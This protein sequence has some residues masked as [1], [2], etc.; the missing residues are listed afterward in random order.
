MYSTL[1]WLSIESLKLAGCMHMASYAG[2]STRSH[3]VFVLQALFAFQTTTSDSE[4]N[5]DMQAAAQ[6]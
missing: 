5:T 4:P 1:N 2:P 3:Q 6:R